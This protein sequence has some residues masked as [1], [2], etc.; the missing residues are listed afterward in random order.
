MSNS[1]FQNLN[2]CDNFLF[3]AALEDPITCRLVLEC[4]IE[5]NIGELEIRVEYTKKYNSEFKCI[6]LDVYQI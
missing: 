5:E 4:I 1:N 2:L 6:R 3:P